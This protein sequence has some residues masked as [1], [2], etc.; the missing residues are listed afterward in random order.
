MRSR[1]IPG[2]A[3]LHRNGQAHHTTAI[4]IATGGAGLAI[5]TAAGALMARSLHRAPTAEEP[6]AEVE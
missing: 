1:K 2:L 4:A 6:A 3:V 5:G